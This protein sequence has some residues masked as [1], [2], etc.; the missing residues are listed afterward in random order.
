[1][2]NRP[3]KPLCAEE[4]Q[5]IVSL[6]K[7]FDRN[8]PKV[9]PKDSSVQ[10]VADALGVALS[11][12]NRVMTNYNKD[13][14]SIYK[15][16][17]PR[18]RPAHSISSSHKEAVRSYIRQANMECCHITLENIKEFLHK[19][20]SNEEFHITTLRNTLNLWGFEFGKGIRTQHLK[21]KDHV[22]AAR[23]R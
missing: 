18:G 1:M 17:L 6:K 3:W 11:A 5:F 12:I 20:S 16:P 19:R 2:R 10:M 14:E 15:P 7:Y 21:E 8:Q 9:G 13:S 23:R 22:V 4:K